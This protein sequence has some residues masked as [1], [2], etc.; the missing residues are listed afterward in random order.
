MLRM[1]RCNSSVATESCFKRCVNRDVE[2]RL[3][4]QAP[5]RLLQANFVES[6]ATRTGRRAE[7]SVATIFASLTRQTGECYNDPHSAAG[8]TL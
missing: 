7:P 8:A 6:I 1:M 4:R 5:R 2:L 3:K